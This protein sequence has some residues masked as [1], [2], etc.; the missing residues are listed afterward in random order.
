ME[1]NNCK[2]TNRLLEF[3]ERMFGYDFLCAV[4][5]PLIN[6]RDRTQTS[7]RHTFLDLSPFFFL[8]DFSLLNH[9][10]IEFWSEG[11]RRVMACVRGEE[12]EREARRTTN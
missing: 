10:K 7:R 8:L 6:E 5:G 1:S 9:K 2:K 3:E 12:G 4:D 11:E